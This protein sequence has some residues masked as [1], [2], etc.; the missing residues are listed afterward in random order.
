MSIVIHVA[1]INTAIV[2]YRH[3]FT[4]VVLVLSRDAANGAALYYTASDQATVIREF[5]TDKRQ[6]KGYYQKK[7][8]S[9]CDDYL[10]CLV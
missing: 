5:P 6:C 1:P 10:C 8:K 3:L 9:F 2:R 4:L 7:G